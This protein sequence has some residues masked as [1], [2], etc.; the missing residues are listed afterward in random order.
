MC[1][2]KRLFWGGGSF[3]SLKKYVHAGTAPGKKLVQIPKVCSNLRD[4]WHLVRRSHRL[5][6]SIFTLGISTGPF[7]GTHFFSQRTVS[8]KISEKNRSSHAG[9]GP[10]HLITGRK[11]APNPLDGVPMRQLLKGMMF[12]KSSHQNP[13]TSVWTNNL[14]AYIFQNN[15]R[16]F[17]CFIFLHKIPPP[18]CHLCHLL[19]PRNCEVACKTFC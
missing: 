5:Q 13:V 4:G 12:Y 17:R 18:K 11:M 3:F 6:V 10:P 7:N 2:N 19:I 15:L 9:L 1:P 8:L 16:N 14:K